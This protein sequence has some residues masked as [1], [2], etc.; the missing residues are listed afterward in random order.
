MDT[1]L[2]KYHIGSYWVNEV[3]P[4][5]PAQLLHS[6]YPPGFYSKEDLRD[7][8][9]PHSL[10][11][12][13]PYFSLQAG[14]WVSAM[15]SS[16][17]ATEVIP[18]SHQIPDSDWQVLAAKD[19][20]NGS[21]KLNEDDWADSTSDWVLR[22]LLSTDIVGQNPLAE[23]GYI[24]QNRLEKGDVLL[25]N[26]KLLHRGGENRSDKPRT[27]LLL[28]WIM[29]FGVKMESLDSKGVIN[30][31]SGYLHE[32]VNSDNQQNINAELARSCKENGQEWRTLKYR[33][34]GPTF[35]S[36]I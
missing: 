25:F 28:Q 4:G 36:T 1:Y 2:G 19:V 6:D 27:A 12:V 8:F 31:L 13:F 33:F 20:A 21:M 14:V 29:P 3:A 5:G 9:S 18:F 23:R 34:T 10:A 26:R 17:G 24:V 7:T 35:Q 11:T 22:S 16:N 32:V 30:K 15:D